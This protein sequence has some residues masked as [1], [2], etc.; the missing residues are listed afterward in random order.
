MPGKGQL[1]D[2]FQRERHRCNTELLE[3]HVFVQWMHDALWVSQPCRVSGSGLL[4]FY[5]QVNLAGAVEVAD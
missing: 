2:L 3:I 4:N 5:A 1:E